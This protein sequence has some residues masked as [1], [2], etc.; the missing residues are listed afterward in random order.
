MYF[1]KSSRL[2]QTNSRDI[3]KQTIEIANY[4]EKLIKI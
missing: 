4:E 1:P 3:V 2:N